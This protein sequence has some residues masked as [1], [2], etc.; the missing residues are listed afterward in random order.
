VSGVLRVVMI[1]IADLVG[2]PP[3]EAVF[4]EKYARIACVIDE[5]INEVR[6]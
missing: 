1:A 6:V 3:T 4:F 2:R 5:V